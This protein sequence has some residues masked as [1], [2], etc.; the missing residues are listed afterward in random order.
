MKQPSA[1]HS[2]FTIER[3]YPHPLERV[4]KAWSDPAAKARWFI[5]PPGK[6]TLRKRE[7]DF[8]LGG[9]ECVEGQVADGPVTRFDAHYLDIQPGRRLV[10]SYVMHLDQRMISISLATV[11]FEEAG[12]ETRLVVTEQG[13]FVNGYEDNGNR[14]KGTRDLLEQIAQT[15]D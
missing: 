5:G 7:M 13:A 1:E 2:T 10:Y 3:R 12:K 4:Y 6:W 8:R 9:R 11:E 15:L 14:E